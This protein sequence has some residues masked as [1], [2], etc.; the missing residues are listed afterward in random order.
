MQ[1]YDNPF[2]MRASEKMTSDDV[3]ISLLSDDTLYPLKDYSDRGA[4]WNNLTYIC[5][6]PGG[7]KT[8]MLRCFSP[9]VLY[10]VSNNRKENDKLYKALKSMGVVSGNKILKS[11]A[12]LLTNRSY[13]DLE[14]EEV[15]TKPQARRLLFALLN[16]R[17]TLVAIKVL[18]ELKTLQGSKSF[19]YNQLDEITFTPSLDFSNK[20]APNPAP[21]TALLSSKLLSVGAL[22]TAMENKDEVAIYNVISRDY[23]IDVRNFEEINKKSTTFLLWIT[24]EA[25]SEF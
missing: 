5:S 12:Y 7:G 13:A 6:A 23:G 17:F 9:S 10:K 1:Q 8:T 21:R 18:Q 3:F 16:A 25:Y 22:L 24:G 15:F 19:E 11:G 20:F 2:N 4:L 14:D